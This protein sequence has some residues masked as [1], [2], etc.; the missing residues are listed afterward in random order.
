[1][2]PFAPVTGKF[3]SAVRRRILLIR[4]AE[5]IAVATA[6]ASA[7]GL[8]LLPLAWWRGQGALPMAWALL[9]LGLLCGLFWGISR[10]PTRLQAAVE[11]DRQLGLDDLLG[12]ILQ[13]GPS[14]AE[15]AWR[16][17]LAAFAENR[18]RAL[19]PSVVIV[20]RLGL[21]A[22]AGVGILGGLLLTCA[23]LTARPS[24][25]TAASSSAL[26]YVPANS[27]Q[28]P[29]AVQTNL[30][31]EPV[32]TAR[33]PGPGGTDDDSHRAFPQIRPDDSTGG[34][35]PGQNPQSHS[36]NA[37][38]SSPGTGAAV[39]PSVKSSAPWPQSQDF[40]GDISRSGRTTAGGGRSDRNASAPGD[41]NSTIAP[42]ASA[43]VHPP[44]WITTAWPAD[45]AAAE[46]AISAGRVPDADADLVRDYFRRE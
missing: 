44:P 43:A 39:T 5:S 22:W 3:I 37:T 14:G 26:A 31:E 45:A 15:S 34:A 28:S 27:S 11:A 13:L 25:V 8:A 40:S 19:K 4:I 20:S 1:V 46:D 17:S 6:I 2:K 38:G 32:A 29:D 35:I 12:T 21:R 23:A 10:R 24:D 18:C 16:Q 42:S 30:N 9:L 41:T 33:P 7:A 36:S